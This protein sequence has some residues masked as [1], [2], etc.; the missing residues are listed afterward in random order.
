MSED[1]TYCVALTRSQMQVIRAALISYPAFTESQ[2]KT[3]QRIDWQLTRV[4]LEGR[5]PSPATSLPVLAAK[6][7]PTSIEYGGEIQ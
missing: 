3:V 4:E 7:T 6:R 1:K 5:P 2:V